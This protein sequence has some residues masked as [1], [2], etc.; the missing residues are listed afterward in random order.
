MDR[1]ALSAIFADAGVKAE[2]KIVIF[3]TIDVPQG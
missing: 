3:Y 1:P 2:A